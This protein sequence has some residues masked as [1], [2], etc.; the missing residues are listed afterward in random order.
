[1][2]YSLLDC[3]QSLE[4][5]SAHSRYSVLSEWRCNLSLGRQAGF[6]GEKEEREGTEGRDQ[7]KFP[8]YT[9]CKLSEL[10]IRQD[11]LK[12]FLQS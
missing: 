11:V 12:E 9:L 1:M 7:S 10:R 5:H 8:Y 2:S 6:R 3:S 4:G